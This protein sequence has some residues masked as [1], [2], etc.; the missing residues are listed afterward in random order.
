[1]DSIKNTIR[2]VNAGHNNP[3]VLDVE[4]N[5]IS[6]LEV[7]GLMLGILDT[8]N[9]DE[10]VYEIKS[11]QKIILYSDGITEA[12]NVEGDFYGEERFEKWLLDNKFLDP[13]AMVEGIT[14]ELN[15]F[16]KEAEQSDDIT[17]IVI[18]REG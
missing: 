17:I 5:S 11:N 15:H 3:Y 16:R 10:E 4:R 18:Q 1:M 13:D 2:Y 14:E 7:G 9:Y 8:V 6:T 12:R